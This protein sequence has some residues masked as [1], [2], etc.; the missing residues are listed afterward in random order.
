MK[1]A[2]AILEGD[3]KGQISFHQNSADGMLHIKGELYHLPY[4]CHGVHIHEFGD[5]SN[6]CTSAGEHLNPYGQPHGGQNSMQRHLGDLGNVCST[7][8][9]VTRFEKFDHMLSLFGEH[10]ILGRSIVVHGMEDDLGLGDNEESKKTGNSGSRLS[11][12][13]IGVVETP[14]VDKNK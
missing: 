2:K 4:G 12:G 9:P 13:I 3:V 7:G 8:S 5:T 11:C 1:S 10:N 14:T 6:G